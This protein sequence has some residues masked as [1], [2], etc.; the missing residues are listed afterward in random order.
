MTGTT[1]RI[2]EQHQCGGKNGRSTAD[3]IIMMK[4]VIDNNAR[5]NKK[6]YTYFA[7]AY[8]C[9]DKLWLKD[10]LLELW[11]AGMRGIIMI[12]FHMN[13][14]SD[15]IVNTPVGDTEQLHLSIGLEN[16]MTIQE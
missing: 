15:I 2:N 14:K 6:P 1:I 3:N 9:F 13:R 11:E 12:I 10:C 16:S 7:D 8:K 4:A 5:L